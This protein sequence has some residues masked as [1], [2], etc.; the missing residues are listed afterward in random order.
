MIAIAMI[1]MNCMGYRMIQIPKS[2]SHVKIVVKNSFIVLPPG[3]A[4]AVRHTFR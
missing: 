2:D 4:V 3:F 1:V